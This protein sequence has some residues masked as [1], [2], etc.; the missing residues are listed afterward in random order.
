LKG[1]LFEGSLVL[2]AIVVD[3]LNR[4]RVASA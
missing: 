4:E 3:F 1:E 2:V